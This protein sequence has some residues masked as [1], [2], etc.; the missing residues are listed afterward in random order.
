MTDVDYY[1]VTSAHFENLTSYYEYNRVIEVPSVLR[2]QRPKQ[3]DLA[4]P[5]TLD[6]CEDSVQ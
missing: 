5:K 4:T 1:V 6:N 3:A 2:E